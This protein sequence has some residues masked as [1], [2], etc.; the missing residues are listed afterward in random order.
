M[1]K[2]LENLDFC[3]F[4]CFREEH[5]VSVFGLSFFGY[6]FAKLSQIPC[7]FFSSFIV[8]DFGGSL[9]RFC[10]ESLITRGFLHG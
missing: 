3:G 6:V 10:L 7:V 9:R 8:D 4:R 5:D 2:K 1:V